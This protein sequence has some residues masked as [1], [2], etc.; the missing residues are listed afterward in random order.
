MTARDGDLRQ[1]GVCVKQCLNAEQSP[2]DYERYAAFLNASSS[3]EQ[4]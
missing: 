3:Q 1:D 2:L 4:R